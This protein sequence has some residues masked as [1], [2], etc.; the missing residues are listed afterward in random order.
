ME[1]QSFFFCTFKQEW[2]GFSSSARSKKSRWLVHFFF[3]Y[4]LIA[5][6]HYFSYPLARSVERG[7]VPCAHGG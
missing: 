3:L 2:G 6:Q 5:K 1:V 7:F 4:H